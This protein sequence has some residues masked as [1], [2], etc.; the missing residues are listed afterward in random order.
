MLSMKSEEMMR[1]GGAVGYPHIY[2]VLS[3]I[4][5][6]FCHDST[7]SKI[8]LERKRSS[9]LLRPPNIF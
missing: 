5:S 3:Y 8:E 1:Q 9:V 6:Y 2:G 4:W 7:G